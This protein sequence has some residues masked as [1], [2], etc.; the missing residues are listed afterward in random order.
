MSTRDKLL[1]KIMGNKFVLKMMSNRVVMKVITA[2]MK[3]FMWLASLFSGKK[4]TKPEE[5]QS[6]ESGNS[7]KS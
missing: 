6:P 5:S 1:L 3:A 2:E 7:S 4:E